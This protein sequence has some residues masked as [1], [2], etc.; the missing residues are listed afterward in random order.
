MTK[1]NETISNRIK[2]KAVIGIDQSYGKTGVSIE[3]SDN[4]SSDKKSRTIHHDTLDFNYLSK[5]TSRLVFR[6][7][8]KKLIDKISIKGYKPFIIVERIRLRSQGFLS[9]SYIA[10]TGGLLS[11]IFDVAYEYNVPV[12]SVDTRSWKSKIVG[13][14]K[15]G[16]D[17]D[18]KKPTMDFLKKEGY[19]FKS[20]DEADAICIAKYGFLP[21]GKQKLKMEFDPNE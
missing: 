18:K 1:N 15:P 19:K 20:D 16:P 5:A 8:L 7:Q 4:T 10:T 12:Y 17:G 11:C 3:T 13:T 14:S 6:K 21:G 2:N 9:L